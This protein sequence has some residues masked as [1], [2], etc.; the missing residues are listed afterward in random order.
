MDRRKFIGLSLGLPLALPLFAQASEQS[1]AEFMNE[2]NQGFTDYQQ[3]L[4]QAFKQYQQLVNSEF[5]SYQQ[6]V[7]KKWGDKQ[8]GSAKVLVRYSADMSSREII[9]YENSTI[10]LEVLA[11]KN[12]P[13]AKVKLRDQFLQLAGSTQQDMQKKDV[14]EQRIS[15]KMPAEHYQVVKPGNEYV[16]AD[17]LTGKAKPSEEQVSQ[18][19]SQ[20]VSEAKGTIRAAKQTG[21]QVYTLTVPLARANANA[22]SAQY[23][24]LVKKYAVQENIEPA[25]IMAIMHSE[26]AFNPMARSHIPAY[27]LMQIVPS[28]AGRDATAKVYGQQRL[29]SASYLYNSENNIKIGTAYLNILFY[30]YL[31]AINNHESRMYCTIA[32]YNTG[33][34]N[35][36]KAFTRNTNINQASQSI[37]QLTP[38]QVYNRLVSNLPY[39]ET[40]K[41]LPLV[42]SRYKTYKAQLA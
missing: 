29:L 28:S 19:V 17:L 14:I 36:A 16:V 32:A 26:S 13:Q 31:K 24:P 38:Q 2:Q 40:R 20:A 5:A 1:F 23:L 41:Y 6:Q 12:S 27:G 11:E 22:K 10:T 39:A 4:E 34:G 7:Q 25:L 42:V 21:M 37:N 35:V 33:A 18:A 8:I 9:D 15:S 3:E 30:R